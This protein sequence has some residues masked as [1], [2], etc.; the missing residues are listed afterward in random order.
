MIPGDLGGP[1]PPTGIKKPTWPNTLRYPATS[2]YSITSLPASRVALYSVIQ[3]PTAISRFEAG[4]RYRPWHSTARRECKLQIVARRAS[5]RHYQSRVLDDDE[6]AAQR[7]VNSPSA[8]DIMNANRALIAVRY[9]RPDS[10]SDLPRFAP[11]PKR[12][13]TRSADSAIRPLDF[14]RRFMA[15]SWPSD[16]WKRGQG[17]S[18]EGQLP[19]VLIVN[20]SHDSANALASLLDAHGYK[21]HIAFDWATASKPLEPISPTSFCWTW[22]CRNWMVFISHDCF[23]KTS[24]SKTAC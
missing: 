20:D 24:N 19:S 7:A 16:A 17:A 21:T 5:R 22:P 12:C 10:R 18:G 23:E 9:L 2:V 14:K 13:E 8:S 3:R 4:R 11:M 15:P 1:L 6:I